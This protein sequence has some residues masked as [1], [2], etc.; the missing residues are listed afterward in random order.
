[1]L[2]FY[3]WGNWGL[4]ELSKLSKLNFGDSKVIIKKTILEEQMIEDNTSGYKATAASF[5][6]LPE[7]LRSHLLQLLSWWIFKHYMCQ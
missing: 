6:I 5:F 3:R 1:M 4:E 7:S 2:T